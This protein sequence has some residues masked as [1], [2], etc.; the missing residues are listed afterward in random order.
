MSEELI[1]W[2]LSQLRRLDGDVILL[3]GNH[4]HEI[5]N[6]LATCADLLARWPGLTI[7]TDPAGQVVAR[8]GN[9]GLCCGAGPCPS[10]RGVPPAAWPACPPAR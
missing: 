5:L 3:P 4:D 9:S 6:R 8:P 1:G 10:T 7:I 2:T